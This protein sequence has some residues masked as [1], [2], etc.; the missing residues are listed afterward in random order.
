MDAAVWENRKIRREWMYGPCGRRTSIISA[1]GISISLRMR[2]DPTEL[3][4]IHVRTSARSDRLRAS[5]YRAGA[6]EAVDGGG[7]TISVPTVRKRTVVQIGDWT[8]HSTRW[9]AR[10]WAEGTEG[11]RVNT[12]WADKPSSYRREQWVRRN[13]RSGMDSGVR[14]MSRMRMSSYRRTGRTPLGMC[15]KSSLWA[16]RYH[17]RC[18]REHAAM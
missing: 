14:M 16:G 6:G 1:L 4:S 5:S 10:M 7:A 3:A 13:A 8:L 2:R 18:V 17:E 11:G 15:L 12:P 9:R